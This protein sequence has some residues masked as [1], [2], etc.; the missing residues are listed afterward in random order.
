MHS[1]N[2]RKCELYSSTANVE[3]LSTSVAP[4]P[5]P[6]HDIPSSCLLKSLAMGIPI[7][8]WHRIT[9]AFNLWIEAKRRRLPS[10]VP[11][12]SFTSSTPSEYIHLSTGTSW[13]IRADWGGIANTRNV[14][15][16]QHLGL[17][18]AVVVVRAPLTHYVE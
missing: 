10:Y 6:V 3:T 9:F 5:D 1:K 2:T 15:D 4:H 16:N 12:D 17:S 8:I 14:Y 13:F 11:P 18:W 7:L